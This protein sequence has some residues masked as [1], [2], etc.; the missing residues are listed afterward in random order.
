M[1]GPLYQLITHLTRVRLVYVVLA[2]VAAIAQG[3]LVHVDAF[4]VLYTYSRS[5]EHWELDE[6][7]VSIGVICFVLLAC[8]LIRARDLRR[9]VARRADAEVRLQAAVQNMAQ[10]LCLFDGAH[11]LVVC[12]RRYAEMF[13]LSPEQVRPGTH[14][15]RILEYRVAS[16][17]FYNGEA[18]EDYINHRLTVAR[19]NH[20]ATDIRE[21]NDGRVIATVHQPMP[22]GGW[23]AT[24]E[25]IT[26]QR[27]LEA[28]IAHLAHHDPLTDLANRTLLY[29]NLQD[30][31]ARPAKGN[32]LAVLCL[33]LDRF[34]P[35]NDVLGHAVGDALLQAVASRLRNCVRPTDT[36]ARI[37]GDEFVVLMLAQNPVQEATAL[38][39]R[40][41][42][43]LNATYELHGRQV[44]IGTS[45][46]IAIS[47]AHGRDPDSLLRHADLALYQAKKGRRGSYRFYEEEMSAGM[48]SRHLLELDL[49]KA[50]ENGEFVLHYQ[51]QVSLERNELVGFEALLRWPHPHRGELSPRDFI[52]LAEETGLIV[53][54]GE[55]AIKQACKDATSWPS[56]IKVAVN[57]SPVQFRSQT[58]AQKV[59]D[60]VLQSGLPP[61]RLELEVTESV[62][63]L[64]DEGSLAT[65]HQLNGLGV[66]FALDDFGTGYSSLSYLRKF[67]FHKIKLDR[68]FVQHLMAQDDCSAT[69][70]EAVANL[71]TAL[72]MRTTAEGVESREQLERAR[73]AGCTEV[74]GFYCGRPMPA[75]N[76]QRCYFART[77]IT[78]AA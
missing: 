63:M 44:V 41:L 46:G 24:L 54:I 45:V 58:L 76:V 66:G 12:N 43:T 38:A 49:Q 67:P 5:H 11:K 33:D 15:R 53:A 47:P 60:A 26:A 7:F 50:L 77:Q 2:A 32:S 29:Q 20:F 73:A 3:L 21:L 25:D 14:F 16:G 37:G 70:V 36:V 17:A 8:L 75:E 74:Q 28:R 52:P 72:G 78:S 39:A 59:I 71:G 64:E 48:R 18:A 23:V 57:L 27:R 61:E 51:P 1:L 10:G 65:M 19:A 62:L 4:D 6:L 42:A 55:W 34:K 56:P 35:V 9:E 31:L 40:L 22:D 30:A 68:S 13:G 69:I